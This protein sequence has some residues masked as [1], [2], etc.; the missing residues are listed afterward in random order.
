MPGDVFGSGQCL[1]RFGSFFVT[2]PRLFGVRQ[3]GVLPITFAE[4]VEHQIL[5]GFSHANVSSRGVD[6]AVNPCRILPPNLDLASLKNACSPARLS[7]SC[8]PQRVVLVG[9]SARIM[10]EQPMKMTNQRR[11]GKAG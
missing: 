4:Q 3:N 6:D 7:C 8:H 2:D 1:D 11:F 5:L 9:K 10:C